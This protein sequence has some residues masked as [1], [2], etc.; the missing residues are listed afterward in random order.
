MR[1]QTFPLTV[2]LAAVVVL[3]G[4]TTASAD[5]GDRSGSNAVAQNSAAVASDGVSAVTDSTAV[6]QNSAS[7]L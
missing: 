1:P 4:A 6:A 3:G 7:L 5:V 2:T